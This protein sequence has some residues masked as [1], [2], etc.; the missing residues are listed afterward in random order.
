MLTS[1]GYEIVGKSCHD[2]TVSP[3][4]VMPGSKELYDVD[5]V[6]EEMDTEESTA[7][8]PKVL[9]LLAKKPV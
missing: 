8:F 6:P 3:G 5:S 1:L 9:R 4:Y 7:E 2:H